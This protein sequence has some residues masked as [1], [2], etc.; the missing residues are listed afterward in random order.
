V[1]TLLLSVYKL[2]L[3]GLQPLNVSM[4]AEE[5]TRN[6]DLIILGGG[7][8]GTATAL[9][10][11]QHNPSLSAPS[12]LLQIIRSGAKNTLDRPIDIYFSKAMER[13]FPCR[14]LF[15]PTRVSERFALRG[16]PS[17]LAKL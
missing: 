14:S 2:F 3:S 16:D 11:R 13:R 9:S 12:D 15:S 4:N 6:F 8:A 17:N 10:L 7:L 5:R 1:S